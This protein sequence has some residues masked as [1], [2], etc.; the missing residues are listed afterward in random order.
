MMTDTDSTV[1][2]DRLQTALVTLLIFIFNFHL[3]RPLQDRYFKPA[4]SV[5]QEPQGITKSGDDQT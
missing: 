4:S 1:E 5:P 2:V 3:R